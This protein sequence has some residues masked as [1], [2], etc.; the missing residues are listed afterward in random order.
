MQIIGEITG[1]IIFYILVFR[2]VMCPE[3]IFCKQWFWKYFFLPYHI[4]QDFL[5]EYIGKIIKIYF[6]VLL[7]IVMILFLLKT[8]IQYDKEVE[9]HELFCSV[10][11][12]LIEELILKNPYL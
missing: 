6:Y 12:E 5:R 3:Y 7:G 10:Y 9:L 8:I 1:Y 4:I 11:N 2:L